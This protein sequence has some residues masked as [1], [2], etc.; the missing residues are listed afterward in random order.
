[1]KQ[2]FAGVLCVCLLCLCGCEADPDVIL[3]NGVSVSESVSAADSEESSAADDDTGYAGMSSTEETASGNAIS[4]EDESSVICAYICGAVQNPG[5]YELPNSARIYQLV[6]MAG[7]LTADADEQSVNLAQFLEDG[8]MVWIPTEEESVAGA[9]APQ[10]AA[11]EVSSEDAGDDSGK[12]NINT[13][14]VS[15]LTTL[16]GIG[17]TKAA[18]IVAWREEHGSFQS[19]EEIMLV[20]GI[21]EGTYEK[22]REYITV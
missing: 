21:A 12:V 2:W 5:V 9:T 3:Q 4:A 6:E 18:A 14:D 10:Q 13:A 16:N 8:E 1:M 11:D 15:E 20:S 17:E 19:I 22:I 7:G